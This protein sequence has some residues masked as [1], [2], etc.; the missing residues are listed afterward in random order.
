MV[1]E[2]ASCSVS[3]HSLLAVSLLLEDEEVEDCESSHASASTIRQ[4]EE[5]EEKEEATCATSVERG[6]EEEEEEEQV[7]ARWQ[8]PRRHASSVPVGRKMIT[9]EV[10]EADEEAEAATSREDCAV[11]SSSTVACNAERVSSCIVSGG[12]V[13]T[14]VL[15]EKRFVHAT[16]A[17]TRRE[18][19]NKLLTEEADVESSE[20]EEVEGESTSTLL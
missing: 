15:L 14:G 4:K 6:I 13:R 5:E 20:E 16:A 18:V 12:T 19:G 3:S 1:A 17:N 9:L 8:V 2:T 11:K 7:S 10:E